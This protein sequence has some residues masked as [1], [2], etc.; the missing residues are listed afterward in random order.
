MKSFALLYEEYLKKPEQRLGQ[1][2][3][4]HYIKK[5]WPELYYCEDNKK[6]AKMI[7][8]YLTDIQ[9]QDSLPPKVI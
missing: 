4:N 6:A 7:K 8:S 2:F 1:F 3:A 5:A 9:C